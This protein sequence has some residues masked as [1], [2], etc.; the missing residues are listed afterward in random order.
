M[1]KR[2]NTETREISKNGAHKNL[3]FRRQFDSNRPKSKGE[4]NTLPSETVPDQSL[5]ILQLLQNHARGISSDVTDN[6]GE[7]F[8][9][10]EIRT[11]YDMNDI[12]EHKEE[13]IQRSKAIKE[14]IR[15]EDKNK[16]PN[17]PVP[18]IPSPNDP[19]DTSNEVIQPIKKG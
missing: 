12:A 11:Y 8:E 18:P 14:R 5:T 9:D 16:V 10:E 3:K 2:P 15:D 1:E 17:Q 4:I 19:P 6:Q 13:L 7:Y